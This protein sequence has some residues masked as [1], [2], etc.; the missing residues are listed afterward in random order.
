MT[1]L[2]V[3]YATLGRPELA[4]KVIDHLSVQTR[5]P[6]MV[7]VS[8]VTQADIAGLEVSPM[9]PEILLGSKGSCVQRNRAIDFVGDKA[10]ILLFFDDDFVPAP[11]F[12]AELVNIFENNPAIAGVTGRVLADGIKTPGIA[13]EDA[14]RQLE[15]DVLPE[16]DTLPARETLYG[17][18]MA[19]RVSLARDIRFDERLPLYG[20]LE[21]IDYTYR[22]AKNGP[23]VTSNRSTG[24]HLGVKGGRTSGVKFGYSQIANPIYML[25][26]KTI[27]PKL[28]YERLARN[29]YANLIYSLKPEPYVDRLGRLRG[30]LIAISDFCR[31]RLDPERILKMD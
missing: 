22:V 18:N 1:R 24:I 16:V 27:P 13:F 9:A 25:R 14:V 17:C 29:F 7:V 30:N 3:I 31:G 21:D 10:D 28:A 8:A 12:L 19:I 26:K 2:A 23:M 11:T 6:D 5:Q 15:G 20:W 4:K